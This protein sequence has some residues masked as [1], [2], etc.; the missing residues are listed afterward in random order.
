MGWYIKQVKLVALVAGDDVGQRL[1]DRQYEQA[2]YAGTE[3]GLD[4]APIAPRV[5]ERL[6]AM[7]ALVL[8]SAG[9]VADGA[10]DGGGRT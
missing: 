2:T 8:A 9:A 4:I 5:R 6:K 10:D 7:Q 3:L 1:K